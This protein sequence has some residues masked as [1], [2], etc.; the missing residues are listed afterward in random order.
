MGK[1]GM[2][3]SNIAEISNEEVF[4]KFQDFLPDISLIM[5]MENFNCAGSV[6]L[7]VAVA[8][9]NALE[10]QERLK[11]DTH[12]IESSSGNL[13]V[14]LSMVCAQKQLKFTCVTDPNISPQVLR[15][16]KA[17]NADVITVRH[18]EN[19]GYVKERLRVIDQLLTTNPNMIWVDQYSNPVNIE[20][21]YNQTAHAIATNVRP[22]DYLFLGVGSGGSLMGCSKY[23]R[24]HS[25]NTK[26]IGV[27]P[28]GSSLFG[29]V[30]KRRFIPGIGGARK[31]EIFCQSAVDDYVSVCETA[32]L[33]MC[34]RMVSSKGLLA[35][36]S[37]A[38]S[39]CA[40]EQYRNNIPPGS[41]VVML[42][43][44]FGVNYIDTIY[45]PAWVAEVTADIQ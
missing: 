23:F 33:E 15:I 20:I 39:L 18:S 43:P 34:N 3:F 27:D 22:V 6:K 4:L 26:I 32:T 42:A 31:P 28:V 37:T 30:P 17:Y 13:G 12:I 40:I 24:E 35:G 11:S 14:A 45:N 8:M 38:T 1:S 29:E 7:K 41:N 36:G 44:D 25:P 16:M 19:F 2:M 9:I 10:Q 5:K 21:H